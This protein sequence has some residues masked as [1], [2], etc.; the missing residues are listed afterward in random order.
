VNRRLVL[1][2]LGLCL[3]LGFAQLGRWQLAREGIKREQLAAADAALSGPARGLADALAGPP[4]AIDKVAGRAR[5]TATPRLW[6]DNQRRGQQVGMRLYCA[7]APVDGGPPL[8]VDLGWLPVAPDRQ[9]P[10]VPCPEGDHA[11]AGLL[12]PPPAVGLRLGPGLVEQ[13]GA[14]LATRLDPAEVSAAWAA[15]PALAARVLRLDPAVPLGHARDLALLSNTLPPE[16]H[17]G[18]AIQW[19][20]LALATLVILIVLNLRRRP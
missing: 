14:W 13:G 8:L 17:R 20:G 9:L 11:L 3:A 7:A 19:F 10:D 12:A 6:L 5:F 1:S 4:G 15:E 16:K 18:Y 2:V